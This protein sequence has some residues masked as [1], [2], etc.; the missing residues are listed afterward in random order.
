MNIINCNYTVAAKKLNLKIKINYIYLW[1]P[2]LSDLT[3]GD[4]CEGGT[5]PTCGYCNL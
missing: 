2:N 4:T 3:F 5:E 1:R